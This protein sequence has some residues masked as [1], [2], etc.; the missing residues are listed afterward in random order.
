[1]A[2]PET[3]YTAKHT[4]TSPIPDAWIAAIFEKLR[5]RYLALWTKAI[6]ETAEDAEAVMQEWAKMLSSCT[7]EQIKHGLEVW[8]SEFPPNV[9]QF[10]TA[11]KSSKRSVAHTV[12]AALPRPERKKAAA[13]TAVANMMAVIREATPETEAKQAQAKQG[14]DRDW[15]AARGW[16]ADDKDDERLMHKHITPMP[17]ARLTNYGK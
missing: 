17:K 11:C 9:Y 10:R 13:A 3:T 1:M 7:G 12:H 5:R 6:G 8:D 16:S 14:D 15:F 2:K 4:Q